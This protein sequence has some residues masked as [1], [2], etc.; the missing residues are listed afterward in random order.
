MLWSGVQVQSRRFRLSPSSSHIP[1]QVYTG[2]VWPCTFCPATVFATG[3]GTGSDAGFGA[4]ASGSGVG[5]GV[6]LCIGSEVVLEV[7][8]I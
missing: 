8:Y 4:G 3:A 6:S 5:A 7:G 2:L 1:V